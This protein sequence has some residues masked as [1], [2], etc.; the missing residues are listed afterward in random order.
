MQIGII[1][2]SIREGRVGLEVAEWVEGLAADR[3]DVD[4]VLIDLK[5]FDVPLFTSETLPA[6]AA[7]KY[8]NPA[9][10]RWADAIGACDAYVFVT[11]EYNHGVPGAFKNA[12]DSIA[13]WMGKPVAFV[14][15]GA[16]GGVRAVEQWRQ[17]LANFGVLDQRPAIEINRF[18]E[19][20]GDGNFLPNERRAGEAAVL[21][22]ALESATAMTL[23]N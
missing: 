1:A 10:Q 16:S 14:S 3:P 6:M 7:G 11:P 8:D 19:F 17:I 22:D 9:V 21:F 13:E 5:D 15:Y 2:G 23:N 20:D 12:V 18:V 4:Y